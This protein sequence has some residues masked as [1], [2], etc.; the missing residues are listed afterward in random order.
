MKFRIF[1]TVF[2]TVTGVIYAFGKNKDKS[3]KPATVYE[4]TDEIVLP[5]TPV[6]DQNS[7]GTAGRF[8]G[9][10]FSNRK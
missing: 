1:F 6:E 9:Y 5:A 7:T 8:P 2:L 10:L 4:F 3:D